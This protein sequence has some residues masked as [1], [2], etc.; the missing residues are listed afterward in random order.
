MSKVIST[1]YIPRPLQD[2]IHR[3]MKRFNVLVCHRRFGKTVLAINEMVDRGLRNIQKNPQYAYFAPFHG[4]AKRVAWEYLKE[5]V[6]NIPNIVINEA[7]LRADIPRPDRGDKVRFLLL[8]ADNPTAILGIYLDGVIIDEYAECDPQIWTRVLRPTLSDRNG[9]ALFI[10]TP[11]GQ[12]HFFDVLQ[13]AKANKSGNWYWKVIKASESKIVADSELIEAK[14]TMSPEEYEQEF[15]CSFTAALI[16]AYYGK[17]M[18]QAEKLGRITKVPHDPSVMVETAWDLGIGDTTCIW[19]LQQVGRECRAIDYI[20]DSGRGL[21]FYV[22]KIKDKPYIYDENHLPHDVRARDLSTGH[23]REET[24]RNLGVKN[25][26]IVPKLSIDDRINASRLLIPRM[27]FDK[28]KCERGVAALKN[29]ERKWDAK[30][31]I[32]QSMPLHNW[33]SHGSDAFGHFALNF[34]EAHKKNDRA[35]LPRQTESDYDIFS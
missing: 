10:G 35:H 9:W 4:Q 11:R 13:I 30:N 5:A 26:R 31:K 20:E 21:D 18:E 6:K 8:G 27:W 28:E 15:E 19:F 25:I 22:K 29:Y 1:G 23:S 3:N 34:R 14:F 2:E 33:A 32:Y 7:E 12:N 16:G 17:E 24:L